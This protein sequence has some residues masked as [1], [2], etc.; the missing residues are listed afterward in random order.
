MINGLEN[1]DSTGLR[2]IMHQIV[3]AG[4]PPGEGKEAAGAA[5]NPGFAIAFKQGTIFGG[6]LQ[7]GSGQDVKI[8]GHGD[9][10]CVQYSSQPQ[11][12]PTAETASPS[13]KTCRLAI[14]LTASDSEL[15]LG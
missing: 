15:V 14:H 12:H 7:F 5:D 3:V 13:E 9:C 1:L 8:V 10:T 6:S 2:D 4:D 11:G